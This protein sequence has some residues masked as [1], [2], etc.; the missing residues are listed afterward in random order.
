MYLLYIA[1]YFGEQG[2]DGRFEAVFGRFDVGHRLLYEVVILGDSGLVLLDFGF[3]FFDFC[4]VVCDLFAELF[5][6]HFFGEDALFDL[7]LEGGVKFFA[8]VVEDAL[9]VV[10][11]S[12]EFGLVESYGGGGCESGFDAGGLIELHHLG[13]VGQ[14]AFELDVVEAGEVIA[15]EGVD[16]EVHALGVEALLQGEKRFQVFAHTSEFP[17]TKKGINIMRNRRFSIF[18]VRKRILGA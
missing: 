2:A 7:F 9:I 12:Q 17:N 14:R 11:G 10:G 5:D 4:L 13:E 18:S 16:E 6:L 15:F 3:Q 8:F 1:V